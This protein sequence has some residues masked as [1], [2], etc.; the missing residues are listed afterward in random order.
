[1]AKVHPLRSM[2][3]VSF[4]SPLAVLPLAVGGGG[5]QNRMSNSGMVRINSP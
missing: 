3:E 5:V 2:A 1:M 4:R